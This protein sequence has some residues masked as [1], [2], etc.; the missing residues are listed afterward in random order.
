[1]GI[2]DRIQA[3]VEERERREGITPSALLDLPPEQRRLINHITRSGEQTAAQAASALDV[4][5]DQVQEMLDLLAE[6]GYLEREKRPE[7]WVYRTRFGRKR[8]RQV[9]AGIWSAL[10]GEKEKPEE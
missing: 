4:P 2:F 9:P 6:K 5:L 8:A 7:G 1:M 10:G 3:E